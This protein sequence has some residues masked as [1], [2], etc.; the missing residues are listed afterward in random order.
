MRHSNAT[1]GKKLNIHD[2]D[3]RAI[4]GHGDVRT[5]GIY[6]YVDMASKRTALEKVEAALMQEA[7]D[8]VRCRQKLP[9]DKKKLHLEGEVLS[10]GPSQGNLELHL[11][12]FAAFMRAAGRARHRGYHGGRPCSQRYIL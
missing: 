1:T 6:K 10:G 3:I 5:T 7:D 8:S 12:R 9:S 4:L 2:R 11:L